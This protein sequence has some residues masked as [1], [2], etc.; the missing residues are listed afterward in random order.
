M[1]DVGLSIHHRDGD[2]AVAD[3]SR[4]LDAD[5]VV[6]RTDLA[7]DDPV[8]SVDFDNVSRPFRKHHHDRPP[9]FRLLD[10]HL[11]VFE[12]PPNGLE[13]A[14]DDHPHDLERAERNLLERFH[15]FLLP[16]HTPARIMFRKRRGKPL[17]KI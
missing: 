6:R 2:V 4:A 5:D 11:E 3:F 9:L 10:L 14:L 7:Q 16:F 1:V 15:S 17:S 12:N 8:L 13:E